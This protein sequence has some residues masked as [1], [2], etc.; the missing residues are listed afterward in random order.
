MSTLGLSFG[1]MA[2]KP[3]QQVPGIDPHF[4]KDADAITRLLVR[5]IITPSEAH[6]ARKRL[7]KSIARE[8]QKTDNA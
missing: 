6:K 2:P 5:G 1:A 8:L 3:S 4:D 7:I